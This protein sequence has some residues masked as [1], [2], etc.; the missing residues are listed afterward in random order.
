VQRSENPSKAATTLKL[1]IAAA[2][3]SWVFVAM[4]WLKESVSAG[5]VLLLW[6]VTWSGGIVLLL[7]VARAYVVAKGY[8][9]SRDRPGTGIAGKAWGLL[10]PNVVVPPT[11]IV[12]LGLS[13]VFLWNERYFSAAFFLVFGSV[14]LGSFLKMTSLKSSRRAA[15]KERPDDDGYSGLSSMAEGSAEA[16]QSVEALHAI[17]KVIGV[18]PQKL[19]RSDRFGYEVGTLA[20]FDETLDEL[21]GQLLKRKR[22]IG[23]P[24]TLDGVKTVGDFMDQWQRSTRSRG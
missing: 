11:S 22:Q 20:A 9:W 14:L 1:L 17:S 3:M 16:A 2:L 15:L 18:A 5:T 19:K 21:G 23:A 8:L 10:L 12:I 13:I 4:P 7:T 6:A 24:L